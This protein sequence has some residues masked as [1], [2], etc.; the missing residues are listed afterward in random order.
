MIEDARIVSLI[1]SGTEILAALGLSDRLVGRSHECDY[2]PAIQNLPVCTQPRLDSDLSSEAINANVNQL[3]RSAL[4][5]YDIK[6]DTLKSLQPTHIITQ[7]QCQVCA[8]SLQNVK[9]AVSEVITPL[10]QIISLQ[11]LVLKDVWKDIE[12]VARI[13]QVDAVKLL[14]NLE[15]RVKIVHTRTKGLAQSEI[16]PSVLCIEWNEPLMVAGNWIPELVQIAG[17]KPLLSQIGKHS[18]RI[19]WED[20]VTYDPDIIIF[21]SCGLNLE[22]TRHDT[23]RTVTQKPEWQNLR[24]VRNQRVYV[25]DGNAYFNR[26]GPRLVDS[27]EILAEI[28]HPEIF[29]YNYQYRGWDY[30]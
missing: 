2:P 9:D 8:V 24:A 20:V 12:E 10:P 29:L 22:Q 17:G 5:I 28:I 19:E 14:E 27:L 15:S 13:F 6:I 25:T 26:P 4:S 30:L 1:P 18:P 23:Q 3:L 16:L 11:P 21:M 7:D